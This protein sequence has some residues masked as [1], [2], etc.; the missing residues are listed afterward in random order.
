MENISIDYNL[1][2]LDNKILIN[3]IKRELDILVQENICNKENIFIV[4]NNNND[5][6]I[7]IK[8]INKYY[9][10]IITKKYPF[11]PPKLKINNNYLSFNHTMKTN[12]FRKLLLEHCGIKCFCCE[13]ILCSY[14]WSPGL[15][16][17]HIFDDLDKFKTV[18][19]Q[20]ILRIIVDVIKRKYLINDVNII[21][22]LYI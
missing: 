4:K 20:I 21:D 15:T 10:F 7:G 13:T 18:T 16:M 5:L 3:R 6:V 11:I 17:K 8:R 14:N 22:W 19:H 2:K 12:L 9:E 1:L